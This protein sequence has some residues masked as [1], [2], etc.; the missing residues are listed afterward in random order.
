M[1][2]GA[3]LSRQSKGSAASDL[4]IVRVCP[5]SEDVPVLTEAMTAGNRPANECQSFGVA[6][7][8]A[9]LFRPSGHSTPPACDK[10]SPRKRHSSPD[11]T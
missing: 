6:L 8:V 1:N 9:L 10:P 11:L 3:C 2:R 4:Y 5:D 7:F